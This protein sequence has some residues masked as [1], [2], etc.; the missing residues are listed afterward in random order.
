MGSESA[1]KYS[2]L[3]TGPDQGPSTETAVIPFM[4]QSCSSNNTANVIC[5][6]FGFF[7]PNAVPHTDQ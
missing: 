5:T 6:E 4:K 3:G 7:I 1:P 2:K